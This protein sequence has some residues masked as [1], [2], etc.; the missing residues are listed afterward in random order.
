[1]TPPA[2]PLREGDLL[3]VQ[4]ALRIL[5][6]SKSAFH[7]LLDDGEFPC[8]RLGGVGGHRA[9]VLVLRTDL[10]EFIERRRVGA[11]GRRVA[12]V[13]PDELLTRIRRNGDA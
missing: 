3:S 6:I 13:S 4:K 1:M 10:E 11:T 7:R 5:P 9:R 2:E 12:R 8:V